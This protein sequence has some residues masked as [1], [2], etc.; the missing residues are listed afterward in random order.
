MNRGCPERSPDTI[1][2][3]NGQEMP[4]SADPHSCK[5]HIDA[6]LGNSSE[7]TDRKIV[8]LIPFDVL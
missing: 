2:A 5:E 6:A 8:F 3:Q 1:M 4:K 7:K